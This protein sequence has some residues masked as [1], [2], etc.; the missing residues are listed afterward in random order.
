MRLVS[1]AILGGLIGLNASYLLAYMGMEDYGWR[2]AISC[3][4]GMATGIICGELD[5]RRPHGK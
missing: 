5:S 3:L 4:L 2:L 1:V